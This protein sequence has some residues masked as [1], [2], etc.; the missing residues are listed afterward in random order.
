MTKPAAVDDGNGWSGA[1]AGG[2]SSSYCRSVCTRATLSRAVPSSSVSFA[3]MITSASSVRRNRKSG[4]CTKPGTLSRSRVARPSMPYSVQQFLDGVLDEPADDARNGVTMGRIRPAQQPLIQQLRVRNL[5]GR[6]RLGDGD[7]SADRVELVEP[8][9]PI[10][11][12]DGHGATRHIGEGNNRAQQ[13]VVVLL[14]ASTREFFEQELLAALCTS[15][16]L[17]CIC[18]VD[19]KHSAVR[20]GLLNSKI[21]NLARRHPDDAAQH[22][23]SPRLVGNR[24]QQSLARQI[25][26]PA[27]CSTQ[28]IVSPLEVGPL[29]ER[30]AAR[31]L[32]EERLKRVEYGLRTLSIRS[33]NRV[34]A[35]VA[36]WHRLCAFAK[37]TGAPSHDAAWPSAPGR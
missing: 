21:R 30:L 32:D 6:E 25:S 8:M 36:M 20:S 23:P 22:Q 9:N 1:Y 35:G 10:C 29:A 11:R 28:D 14:L 18:L 12:H 5:A 27:S 37:R 13:M 24:S 15:V 34:E 3:S 2:R 7:M 17:P 19:G 31:H 4:A 16:D 33:I 26:T